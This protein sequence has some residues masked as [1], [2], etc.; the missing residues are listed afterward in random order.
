MI[1]LTK[2]PMDTFA[3]IVEDLLA[4]QAAD[5]AFSPARPV[6]PAFSR[7]PPDVEAGTL[8]EDPTTAQF[9]DLAKR[10]VSGHPPDAQ[11]VLHPPQGDR[12]RV[13]YPGAHRQT[14][15]ELGDARAGPVLTALLVGP[16]RPGRTTGPTFDIARCAIFL[17]R[18][19]TRPGRSSRNGSMRCSRPALPSASERALGALAPLA[20]KLHSMSQDIGRHGLNTG[21]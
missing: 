14:P 16:S 12:G 4:E 1:S 11:P 9:A 5:P 13:R 3:G 19:R 21:G 15:D 6:E 17:L 18:T 2:I 10:P 7:L 20:G 8:I